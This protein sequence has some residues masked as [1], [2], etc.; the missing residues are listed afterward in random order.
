MNFF[1]IGCKTIICIII[2][3]I[4]VPNEFN[5][6]LILSISAKIEMSNFIILLYNFSSIELL[7][8]IFF[9]QCL[10]SVS[11]TQ[12][13]NKHC[14]CSFPLTKCFPFPLLFFV[15]FCYAAASTLQKLCKTFVLFGWAQIVRIYYEGIHAYAQCPF[16]LDNKT[17]LRPYQLLYIVTI[18]LLYFLQGKIE[19]CHKIHILFICIYTRAALSLSTWFYFLFFSIRLSGMAIRAHLAAH[20]NNNHNPYKKA[21]EQFLLLL[22]AIVSR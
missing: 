1:L 15:H 16:L 4:S 5:S 22:N 18:E 13:E 19:I 2:I 9:M 10:S 7:Y 21:F 3:R 8:H 17:N 20:A 11:I 14:L 6:I 12:N